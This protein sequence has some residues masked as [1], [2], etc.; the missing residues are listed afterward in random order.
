MSMHVPTCGT[1][2]RPDSYGNLY[3]RMSG[4]VAGIA[5]AARWTPTRRDDTIHSLQRQNKARS[6]EGCGKVVL[7]IGVYTPPLD[8]GVCTGENT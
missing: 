5:P 2:L 6:A 4:G 7:S 8:G 3:F 1:R